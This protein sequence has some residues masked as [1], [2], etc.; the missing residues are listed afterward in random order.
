LSATVA[1]KIDL[2]GNR[3][4]AVIRDT[5]AYVELEMKKENQELGIKE[6]ISRAIDDKATIEALSKGG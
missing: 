4:L 2:L 6:R 3:S 1:F 5:V